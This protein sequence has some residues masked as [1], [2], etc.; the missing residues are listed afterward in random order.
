MI[1]G[2]CVLSF[3]NKN[4]DYLQYGIWRILKEFIYIRGHQTRP[5]ATSSLPPVCINN[6]LLEHSTEILFLAAFKLRQ[7]S[8]VV[9]TTIGPAKPKILITGLLLEKFANSCLYH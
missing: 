5:M 4:V 1:L 9:V 2:L 6:V 7:Q 8:G 3:Q